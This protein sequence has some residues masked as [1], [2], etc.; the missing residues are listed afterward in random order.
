MIVV[1]VVAVVVVVAVA[2][3]AAVPDGIRVQMPRRG[4]QHLLV[5]PQRLGRRGQHLLSVQRR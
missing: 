4:Q 2:W 1:I 3:D 5:R